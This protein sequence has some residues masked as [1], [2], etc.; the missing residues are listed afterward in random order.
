MAQTAAPQSRTAAPT[1]KQQFAEVYAKEH[2]TTL[3]VLRAFPAD[4]ASYQP[5]QRSDTALKLAWRFVMENNVAL[6]ALKGPV[7]VTGTM[8]PPPPMFG[9][10]IAA[11]EASAK[12]LMQTLPGTPDARLGETIQFPIGP[13]QM[14]DVPV[15]EFLW[16]MLM[17]SIHHRGQLSVY[18]RCAGGKVPSI[19]GLSADEPWM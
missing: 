16:F 19:Y 8:P 7:N 17:D 9:E 13:G 2:V 15:G 11:Y 4:K 5:H 14:G 12:E 3:N 10:V 6:A 18:V 1:P